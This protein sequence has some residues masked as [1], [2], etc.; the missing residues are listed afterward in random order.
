MTGE[1]LPLDAA[2]LEAW[3]QAHV[4]GFSGPLTASKFPTGQSNPT[5]LIETPARRYVMRRKPPA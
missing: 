2:R 4:E 5:Y 3:A 1:A